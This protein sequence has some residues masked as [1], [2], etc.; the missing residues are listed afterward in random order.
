M[1]LSHGGMIGAIG[2]IFRPIFDV[3][4]I[5]IGFGGFGTS[6]L[7]FVWFLINFCREWKIGRWLESVVSRDREVRS[8][9]SFVR[10]GAEGRGYPTV[11]KS[12]RLNA[13]L[14]RIGTC[15]GFLGFEIWM[16]SG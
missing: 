8:R 13:F 11:G 10:C 15:F 5:V 12:I 4:R 14:G 3:V 7:I 16:I 9:R 6:G 1:A 2:C